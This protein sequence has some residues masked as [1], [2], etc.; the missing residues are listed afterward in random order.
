[1]GQQKSEDETIF[2]FFVSR[3]SLSRLHFFPAFLRVSIERRECDIVQFRNKLLFCA[4]S[5]RGIDFEVGEIDTEVRELL[6]FYYIVLT[7][8][9]HYEHRK[10]KSSN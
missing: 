10:W 5:S 3:N 2:A 8:R 9:R 1:M 7:K 4:C 6:L